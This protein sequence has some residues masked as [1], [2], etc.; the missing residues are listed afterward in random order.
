M[1]K[2][3]GK[4]LPGEDGCAVRFNGTPGTKDR[5][6]VRTMTHL[7]SSKGYHSRHNT[8]SLSSDAVRERATQNEKTK[9]FFSLPPSSVSHLVVTPAAKPKR[10][11]HVSTLAQGNI[12]AAPW[13]CEDEPGV[14][15][16][17]LGEVGKV[18]EAEKTLSI[19]FFSDGKSA[20]Y[21]WNDQETTK[22][23]KVNDVNAGVL[24]K[25]CGAL[26]VDRRLFL[27]QT[28]NPERK[29]YLSAT[30]IGFDSETQQHQLQLP[31]EKLSLDLSKTDVRF[32]QP[33][34]ATDTT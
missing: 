22:I 20:D 4:I 11:V 19:S 7:L 5:I 15:Q 21:S 17:F 27:G 6:T 33:A 28:K 32:V 25:T 30:I 29:E 8:L 10:D 26:V 13:E 1:A 16:Y 24:F 31:S 2:R 9:F 3:V 12:V 14:E 34:P 23:L 18:D